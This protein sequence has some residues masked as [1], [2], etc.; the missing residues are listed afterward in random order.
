MSSAASRSPS[1]ASGSSRKSI[2]PCSSSPSE[3][4]QHAALVRA[5]GGARN[6]LGETVLKRRH[7][8]ALGQEEGGPVDQ[9]LVGAV[10]HGA[11]DHAGL[12]EALVR[13]EVPLDP[14]GRRVTVILGHRDDLAARRPIGGQAELEHR[15]AGPG[16]PRHRATECGDLLVGRRAPCPIRRRRS[17]RR[18]PRSSGRLD[19]RARALPPA[20][21]ESWRSGW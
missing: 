6:A 3:A 13:R 21:R 17:P 2:T 19:A 11:A 7:E 9:L 10:E 20:S 16:Q 1:S 15:C 14:V 5:V 18:R 12:R 8:R 4:L